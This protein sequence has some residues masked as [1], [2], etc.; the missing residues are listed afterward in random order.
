MAAIPFYFSTMGAEAWWMKHTEDDRAPRGGDYEM[1]DTIASLSMGVGSLVVPL[2]IR[3]ISLK[4]DP[5]RSW[6]G[7]AVIGVAG[8]AAVAA[9]LADAWV[10]SIDLDAGSIP[11]EGEPSGINATTGAGDEE[12]QPGTD[13]AESVQP[14]NRRMK[15]LARK[16]GGRAAL[17][18]IAAGVAVAAG[19]W[20]NRTMA[21]K[22]FDKRVLPD[23]GTGV[24]PSLA[25]IAGWDFIYYWNHRMM[26]E[27][28]FLWAVHVVHHSSEHYNLSTALRQPVAE[29]LGLFVPYGLL[30]LLGLNPTVIE[31]A[32][33]VN[34]IYQYWIHTELI[35]SI[36]PAEAVLNTA[37]HHRV[38]HGSNRAYLDRNH[39]SILI[40]WDKLFGTFEP[41]DEPVVYGL[42]KNIDTFNPIVVATHEY[43]DIAH[44]VVESRNWKDRLSH[45]F[46][47]PGWRR[48]TT[49]EVAAA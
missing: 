2:I 43:T 36:G 28:R 39:G 47:G 16:I 13:V 46:R 1:A 10:R 29:A 20:A 44:D 7:K 6:R 45:V 5:A 12:S 37:S 40:I 14:R 15:R 19:T 33:G 22:L 32:R 23:W 30:S 48:S 34:L 17:T 26:H 42:T 4:L 35:R 41:E 31:R 27:T 8:A 24:I 25:A 49:A 3:P 38:H 9:V 11:L 21:G 18:S